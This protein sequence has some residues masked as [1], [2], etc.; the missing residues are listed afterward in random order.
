[1]ILRGVGLHRTG[2]ADGS[3]IVPLCFEAVGHYSEAMAPVLI[4][5][6]VGFVDKQGRMVIK[7][8]FDEAGGF[9]EGMSA[10]VSN[11]KHGFID[12]KG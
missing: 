2:D 8:I 4:N 10:A 1:M 7:P 5:D 6:K 9:Y 12:K 11:G 3:V